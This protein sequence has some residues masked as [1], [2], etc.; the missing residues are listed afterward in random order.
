MTPTS[1]LPEG[2]DAPCLP[3]TDFPTTPP[4]G[5][6]WWPRTPERMARTASAASSWPVRPASRRCAAEAA[7]AE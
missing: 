5:P 4:S 7:T 1:L 6:S 2:M 3:R